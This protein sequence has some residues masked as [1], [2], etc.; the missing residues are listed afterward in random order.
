MKSLMASGDLPVQ[1][2]T[3]LVNQVLASD[4]LP[5]DLKTGHLSSISKDGICVKSSV[6]R[7]IG[8]LLT[9]KLIK[10]TQYSKYEYL[11]QSYKQKKT[12]FVT[13]I[14]KNVKRALSY[15]HK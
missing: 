15:I 7:M 9:E 11:Y 10:A 1:I 13:V 6:Y 14:I 8:R 12:P 5:A 3:D 2:L 4:V